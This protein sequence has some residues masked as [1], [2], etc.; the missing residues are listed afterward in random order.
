MATAGGRD[1]EDACQNF[2][3]DSTFINIYPNCSPYSFNGGRNVLLLS[4]RV[5]YSAGGEADNLFIISGGRTD[6]AGICL[7][8]WAGNREAV[9]NGRRNVLLLSRRVIYSADWEG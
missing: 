3:V 5:V 4:G 2:M 1:G 6:W 9:E 7:M 8:V